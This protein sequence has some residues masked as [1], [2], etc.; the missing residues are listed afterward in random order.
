M[1][2]WVRVRVGEGEGEGWQRKLIAT[3]HLSGGSVDGLHGKVLPLLGEPH[4]SAAD[5][6]VPLVDVKEDYLGGDLGSGRADDLCPECEL[7]A[8]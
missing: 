3:A 2:V 8:P 1:W 5:P 7:V 4:L 6:L